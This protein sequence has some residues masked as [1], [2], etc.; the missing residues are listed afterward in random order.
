MENERNTSDSGTFIGIVLLLALI[1]FTYWVF[2]IFYG[3]MLREAWRII[4]IAELYVWW[5]IS[6]PVHYIAGP[7]PETIMQNIEWLQ[8]RSG[9]SIAPEVIQKLNEGYAAI[10][11]KVIASIFIFL[12]I[13]VAIRSKQASINLY[14]TDENGNQNALEPLLKMVA[15]VRP[16]LKRFV[17]ENPADFPVEYRPYQDNRYAQRVSPWDFMR[18]PI[19]PGLDTVEGDPHSDIGPILL[20]DKA[21]GSRFNFKAAQAV[22]EWQLGER[23]DGKKTL[24]K[25]SP[26]EMKAYKEIYSKLYKAKHVAPEVF[27]K[28]AYIRSALMELYSRSTAT[29]SEMQWLKYEDRTLWYCLQDATLEVASAECVGIWAHWHVERAN[30]RAIPIPAVDLAIKW[31]YD[32]CELPDEELAVF[33]KEDEMFRSSPTYW[34]DVR[35]KAV[36]EAEA[37]KERDKAN[38]LKAKKKKKAPTD[39]AR[40]TVEDQGL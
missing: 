10:W 14:A 21:R 19:P 2:T 31:F 23:T 20:H 1:A 40:A 4:R 7:S 6:W 34:E 33:L 39:K 12:G 32:L 37:Q 35:N 26:A 3:E 15:G 11:S 13:R 9:E 17:K 36:K 30:N 28:H 27:G 25:M 16:E 29:T 38:A 24:S 5:V 18:M 22:L 8:A